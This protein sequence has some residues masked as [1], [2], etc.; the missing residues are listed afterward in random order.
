MF[1][2]AN[3]YISVISLSVLLMVSSDSLVRIIIRFV[4]LMRIA[5]LLM[6]LTAVAR[7]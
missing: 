3:A 4:S 2:M 7:T 5:T 6:H 1:S